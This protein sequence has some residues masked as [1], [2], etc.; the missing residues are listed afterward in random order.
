[1]YIQELFHYRERNSLVLMLPVIWLSNFVLD[2][3]ISPVLMGI[4]S[5]RYFGCKA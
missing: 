2:N 3:Y 1:M 5:C 4:E